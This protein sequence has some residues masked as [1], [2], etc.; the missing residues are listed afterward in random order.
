ML[1]FVLATKNKTTPE[2]IE[3]GVFENIVKNEATSN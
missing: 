2:K 3:L 1:I